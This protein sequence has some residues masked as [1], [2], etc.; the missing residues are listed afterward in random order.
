MRKGLS[1]PMH[2]EVGKRDHPSVSAAD[3]DSMG[4]RH[5]FLTDKT[6]MISFFAD[7]SAE[8]NVY[9]RSRIHGYVNKNVYELVAALDKQIPLLDTK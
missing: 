8:I 2:L 6:T 1:F 4:S 5:I 3:D 9:C 7:T